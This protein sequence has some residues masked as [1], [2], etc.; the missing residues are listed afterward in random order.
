MR[1]SLTIVAVVVLAGA[2]LAGVGTAALDAGP[3]S[4]E[5]R[6][7]AVASTLRCPT[8]DNLS[9]ADSPSPMA[10][11]MRSQ[12]AGQ[13]E[14]GRSPD[15]VREWFV[16]RYGPWVLLSPPGEGVGLLVWLVPA[17]ALPLVGGIGVWLL[18]GRRTPSGAVADVDTDALCRSWQTR[19]LEIPDTPAGERL[20]AALRWLDEARASAQPGSAQ[21]AAATEEVAAAWRATRRAA[22]GPPGDRRPIGWVAGGLV[23]VAAIAAALPT[24]IAARGVGDVATGSAPAGDDDI[25]AEQDGPQVGGAQPADVGSR[26]QAAELL[27]ELDDV[28]AGYAD[29]AEAADAVSARLPDASP[30]DR[31]TFGL[32]AL[33]HDRLAAADALAVS[34]L[35]A[36]TAQLEARLLRGLALTADGDEAG[37]DWLQRFLDHAPADHPGR[38]MAEDALDGPAGPS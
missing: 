38:P 31:L 11:S 19:Q 7:Q 12:I 21:R 36:D 4:R 29:P 3:Q 25:L 28:A 9:V 13:L 10:R 17:V 16:D 34:V 15:E 23:L 1:R 32:L 8:C 33:Q 35:D 2:A 5:A 14:Q 37:A 27:A 30:A 24:A 18:R 26:E 20:E 22:G 6:T